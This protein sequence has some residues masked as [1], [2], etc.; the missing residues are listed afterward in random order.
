[1]LSLFAAVLVGTVS[2]ILLAAAIWLLTQHWGLGLL[3]L[4]VACFCA[5]LTAYVWRDFRGKWGLRIVLDR[6]AVT[7]SL[8][9]GRSLIHRVPAQRVTIPYSDIAAV[10]TRLEG[11]RSLGMANMQRAYALRRKSGEWLFLF[12]DRALATA[13]ESSFFANLAAQLSARTGGPLRDLGMVEGCG[14]FLGVWGTHAQE[15]AA[16]SLPPERQA[17]L[18]RRAVFTGQLA[19]AAFLIIM[20]IYALRTFFG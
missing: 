5:G 8:P 20:A 14:G 7:L 1:L 6:D 2:V 13:F 19:G 3:A 4:A 16:P 10:E 15:W 9:A 17:Q 11:Y 18:W 12:E